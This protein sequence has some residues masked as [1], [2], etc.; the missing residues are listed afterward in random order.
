MICTYIGRTVLVICTYI[1]RAIKPVQNHYGATY[2]ADSSR[3][4]RKGDIVCKP[5]LA[6]PPYIV[7]KAGCI[8]CCSVVVDAVLKEVWLR[9]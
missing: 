6:P 9:S 8:G 3:T 2:H 4:G 7:C 5:P 1:S